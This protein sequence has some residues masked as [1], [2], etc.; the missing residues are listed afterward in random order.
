MVG[1]I[2]LS[3]ILLDRRGPVRA[4]AVGRDA[5]RR[6]LRL[7][8]HVD[9]V[10]RARSRCA[11]RDARRG[12]SGRPRRIA[13]RCGASRRCPACV[14]RRSPRARSRSSV[15]DGFGARELR[16]PGVETVPQLA[17]RRAAQDLGHRRFLRDARPL[18]IA[19]GRSF[20]PEEPAYGA[21]P[22]GDG[23]RNLRAHG[24]ARPGLSCRSASSS[25]IPIGSVMTG[26]SSRARAAGSSASSRT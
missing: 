19:R 13:R 1:Q 21:E 20:A 4:R 7:R 26:R 10:H 15:M 14:R 6:R 9:G 8:A 22:V 17:E 18:R 2:T 25:T 3:V 24:L 5:H 16:I 11:A 12:V 23:E